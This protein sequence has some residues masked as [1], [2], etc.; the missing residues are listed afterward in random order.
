MIDNTRP[1]G[2]RLELSPIA[3]LAN[4]YRACA[5]DNNLPEISR[6]Q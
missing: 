4:G 6:S 1:A 3:M 5:R 2:C